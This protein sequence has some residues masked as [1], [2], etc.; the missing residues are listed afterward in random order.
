MKKP[1]LEKL[2]KLKKWLSLT[3]A[4]RRISDIC[5][6]EVTELD[7]LLFALDKHLALS[8]I[9]PSGSYGQ[10][11]VL[12][13]NN[14]RE[15][16]L[17]SLKKLESESGRSSVALLSSYIPERQPKLG[18]EVF[19]IKG[20][21]DLPMIG[22]EKDLVFERIQQISKMPIE[23]PVCFDGYLVQ[24]DD[25][26]YLLQEELDRQPILSQDTGVEDNTY[27]LVLD[28]DFDD[29]QIPTK[30]FTNVYCPAGTFPS[31]Y[32]F[33]IR[34]EAIMEFEKMLSDSNTNSNHQ[35]ANQSDINGYTE[36]WAKDRE[37]IL[38]AAFALLA[39]YPDECRDKKGKLLASKIASLIEAKASL[40]WPDT[41]PPLKV[42]SIADHLR[43]WLKKVNNMK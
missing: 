35:K 7:I 41:Q 17:N 12:E 6:D 34:V 32:E 24:D 31:D 37:Q 19:W 29:W 27:D 39:K 25:I 43:E 28:S 18:K 9:F 38:G 36:R 10:R 16:L 20:L 33:V 8:V 13:Y 21:F 14:K 5:E 22:L 3:E 26:V 23:R 1:Y 42:D 40:F 11:G 2:L 30:Q 4:A 15:E